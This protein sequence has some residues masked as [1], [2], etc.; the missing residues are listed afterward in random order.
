[1]R[2][3]FFVVAIGLL[4]LVAPSTEYLSRPS[5][6]MPPAATRPPV[7]KPAV[8]SRVLPTRPR[9]R[10]DRVPAFATEAKPSNPGVHLPLEFEANRGQAPAQ[11]GYVAHG[12]T[13]S[14]GLSASEIALSLHRSE[15]VA[16]NNPLASALSDKTG[17]QA[18]VSELHLRL[19]GAGNAAT[20]AGLEPK[21]GV[22]NYFIG[23]DPAN[24]RTNV[25]HFGTVKIAEAYPGIDLVFYGNPQQLEYDFQVAPGVDP[26]MIRVAA[27]GAKS[28][29]L[30]AEGNLIL[31][32][33]AGDVQLKHP[34]AYQEIAG[35]RHAVDSEFRLVAGNAVQFHV[36]EYDRSKPLI[37]DPVLL[38]AVQIGGS[39]GNQ[40]RKLLR[41]GK[42]LLD[43]LPLDR[44][45]LSDDP[46]ESRA[47]EVL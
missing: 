45:E 21:P 31:G 19:L 26:G 6:A 1:M 4:A 7:V 18:T 16:Q 27:D 14:L 13:Y 40:G 42:H 34:D 12:P 25:P 3:I 43:R 37:I 39:N 32:T 46:F 24:W 44:G 17:R 36:G 20:M 41:D 29:A 47:A 15:D 2:K 9:P 33:A 11:Y 22:S 30:D 38:Y 10:Q 5:H 35:V 8:T 28:A 23:N